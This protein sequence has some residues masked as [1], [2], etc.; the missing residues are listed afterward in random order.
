MKNKT[1]IIYLTAVLLL[2][3]GCI[4][5]DIPYPHIQAN[6]I[7]LT[8]EGQ[9]GSTT[10]DSTAMTATMA[11]GEETDI[12]AVKIISYRITSG[13][14]VINDALDKTINLKEPAQVTLHLYQDYTWK[15][16]G[17]QNIERYFEVEGQI[18]QSIIDPEA[19]TVSADIPDTRTLDAVKIIK[20]KLGPTSSA[21]S[22]DISA[23]GTIDA[24][25]PV[26]IDIT[27]HGRTEQWTVTIGQV[28]MKV[29]TIGADAFS[30]VAWVYGQCE[31]GKPHGAEYRQTGTETWIQVPET[32]ITTTGGDFNACIAHLSPNTAYEARVFSDGQ[33]GETVEFTTGATPQMPESDFGNW[34]LDGKVW[35]P[36]P[37][38]GDPFW[39]TGNKGATTLGQSNT[40]PSTDTPDGIGYAACLETRFVGIGPLGKLAAG[41]IF[42]GSYVRTVGTNG[43]LSFGRP[44]VDRPVRLSGKYKYTGATINYSTTEMKHLIGQPDTCIVWAALI[45]SEE[46]FEI[47]TQ[48]SDR[49]LFD[50]DG[51]YVIA[52]GKFQTAE[53]VDHYIDFDIEINYKSTSRR[54]RYLLVTASASKYGDYFT[55]GDG[56]TLYLDNFELIY[57]Y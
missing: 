13:A 19:R 18:G 55:G 25:S 16:I 46:P 32:D 12:S 57:D 2:L 54:P 23:G 3:N 49:Q 28:K 9:L 53:T 51:D 21:M 30:C 41:N 17:R 44:W 45:D 24:T 37:Q 8:A 33:Y 35:C 10:I 29:R 7:E 27:A 42:A 38:D 26:T 1:T 52:Y 39:G 40:I 20:A 4:H 50:P 22:P 56:S 36:W 6:I 47:R 43:V 31:S 48:P 14:S 11:F 5:N 15:L 34:W